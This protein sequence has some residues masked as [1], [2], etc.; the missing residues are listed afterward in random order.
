MPDPLRAH[1]QRLLD[2]QV[3][4]NKKMAPHYEESCHGKLWLQKMPSELQKIVRLVA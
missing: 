1:I 4:R 3:R 2:Q